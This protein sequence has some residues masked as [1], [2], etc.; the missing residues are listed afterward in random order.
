LKSAAVHKYWD[1]QPAAKVDYSKIDPAALKLFTGTHPKNR[2]KLAA[3]GRRL[4]STDPNHRSLPAKRSIVSCCDWNSGWESGLTKN[5]YN[6]FGKN[7]QPAGRCRLRPLT[8]AIFRLAMVS[9]SRREAGGV[10]FAR[11][12][13]MV[14]MKRD[15]AAHGPIAP[16]AQMIKPGADVGTSSPVPQP[17]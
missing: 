17:V 10:M 6:W 1:D 15:G 7:H 13:Q 5:H 16:A 8:Q 9:A 11:H 2:A 3:A 4:V 14:Q 12:G